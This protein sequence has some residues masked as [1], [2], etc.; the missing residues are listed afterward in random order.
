MFIKCAPKLCTAKL[1]IWA[2]PPQLCDSAFILLTLP[3]RSQPG[4]QSPR[5]SVTQRQ[6]YQLKWA[7]KKDGF[8]GP[9]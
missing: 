2:N 8:V 9:L 4:K 3:N 1:S 5:T 6:K 7:V